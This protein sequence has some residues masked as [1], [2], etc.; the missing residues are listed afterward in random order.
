[1]ELLVGEPGGP[2]AAALPYELGGVR[3]LLGADL[4]AL[5]GAGVSAEPA[6][7]V[8]ADAELLRR[9]HRSPQAGLVIQSAADVHRLLTPTLGL[10]DHERLVVVCLDAHNRVFAV[11][12]ASV[13]TAQ[14]TIVDPATVFRLALRAGAAAVVVVHNHPSGDASPSPPDAE[15]TK[16][17]MQA[18]LVL[19]LPVLDHVVI[20]G[21]AAPIQS[22]PPAL[23]RSRPL[24]GAASR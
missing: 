14:A 4:L 1:M 23:T 16:L 20:A 15:V 22:R 10:L 2:A 18:G 3:G 19:R 12:L 21:A 13:G 17:L 8:L 5:L 24:A 7:R 6:A 11:R 9:A